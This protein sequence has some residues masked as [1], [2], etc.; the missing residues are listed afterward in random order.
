M[1][2]FEEILADESLLEEVTKEE[3]IYKVYLPEDIPFQLNRAT[4]AKE[5]IKGKKMLYDSDE[6]IAAFQRQWDLIQSAKEPDNRLVYIG[7]SVNLHRRLKEF[8]KYG[9]GEFENHKG[10]R[11][12]WQLT[13]AKK[14]RIE[15]TPCQNSVKVEKEL[16]RENKSR[17][18]GQRP[19][20][21]RKD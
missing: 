8:A 17:H 18:F 5:Y 15:Y 16:I 3:G 2:T 21:N 1:I 13:D 12:L 7:Q 20:A 6:E 14:C 4:T 10:G 19:I 9:V 11:L